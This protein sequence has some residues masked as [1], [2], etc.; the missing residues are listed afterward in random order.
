MKNK[1]I[2]TSALALALVLTGCSGGNTEETVPAD[3][4]VDT[5]A[6][7]IA[8]T[9]ADLS[10]S[11]AADTE[12]TEV[13]TEKTEEEADSADEDDDDNFGETDKFYDGVFHGSG[14]TLAIDGDTWMD[15]SAMMDYVRKAANDSDIDFGIDFT[16]EQYSDAYD[17][18]FIC[19]DS[20]GANFNMTV[21][22]IG[23]DLNIADEGAELYGAIIEQQ[24]SAVEGCTFYGCELDSAGDYDC[25]KAELEM[26]SSGVTMRMVQYCFWENKMQ[27]VIT[28]TATPDE[29]EDMLPE[30]KK[31]LDSV[32]FE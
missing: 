27:M 23:M 21:V 1:F 2:L 13:V 26:T 25:L 32:E 31:V 16:D 17:G 4:A 12:E 22:D 19:P 5:V 14:Y 8:D 24:Y 10:E 18:M 20:E 7:T 11:A 9:A 28:F 30:F 6:D 3:N 15:I 29:Y